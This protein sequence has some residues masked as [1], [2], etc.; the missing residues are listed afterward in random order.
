MKV[1]TRAYFSVASDELSPDELSAR[2]GEQPSSVMTKAS[3][4]LD[5][6]VPKTNT[7]EI[8]SGLEQDA[9]LWRH[10]DALR[11]VVAPLSDR[12]AELCQGEPTAVLQV[13]RKFSPADEE[14]DLGFW[15][16]KYWLAILQQ[17]GAQVDV[18]EYDYATAD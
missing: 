11:E 7:W 18:D 6:P 2:I 8:D 16:D 12:I 17:T 3:K 4:R 5:P 9:P 14:A 15:L 13:V 10:L 1:Q